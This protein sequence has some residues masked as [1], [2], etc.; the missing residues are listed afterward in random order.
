[1]EVDREEEA[2][3]KTNGFTH[4][5][6]T[7]ASAKR[8]ASSVEESSAPKPGASAEALTASAAAEDKEDDKVEVVEGCP[9]GKFPKYLLA[10]ILWGEASEAPLAALQYPFL[11]ARHLGKS[12][13][14]MDMADVLQARGLLSREAA[15]TKERQKGPSRSSSRTSTPGLDEN[16][17][18][19]QFEIFTR[20]L[21]ENDR[22]QAHHQEH[23]AAMSFWRGE[24]INH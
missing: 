18:E 17:F 1:M 13:A 7:R 15:R 3:P 10:F 11:D 24:K 4:P 9:T 22:Q 2:D 16:S 14:E 20:K 19:R 12:D 8:K 6:G 5:H 21:N 23:E